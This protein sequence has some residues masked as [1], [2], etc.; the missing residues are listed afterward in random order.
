MKFLVWGLIIALVV[1]WFLRPKSLRPDSWKKAPPAVGVPEAML[2]CAECGTHFP[3][4][5]A[6]A[7]PDGEIFCSDEHRHRHALR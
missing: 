4:S 6:V 3:A 7:T 2:Q 5:E 1:L